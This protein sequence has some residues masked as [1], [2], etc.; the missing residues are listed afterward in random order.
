MKVYV[1]ECVW[2]YQGS[3]ILGVFLSEEK[4]LE[5]GEK[6]R[7]LTYGDDVHYQIGDKLS[8]SEWEVEE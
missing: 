1:A 7:W 4:A 5:E 8:V 3:E 2:N 6:R